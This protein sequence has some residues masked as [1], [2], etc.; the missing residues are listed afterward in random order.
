MIDLFEARLAVTLANSVRNA[1]M[2]KHEPDAAL[3]QVVLGEALLRDVAD[4]DQPTLAAFW[5]LHARYI[6]LPHVGTRL[7]V[8][9]PVG[10]DVQCEQSM[11]LTDNLCE[12]L[13]SYGKTEA[14]QPISN[15]A[16]AALV[17]DGSAAGFFDD[18]VLFCLRKEGSAGFCAQLP[19]LILPGSTVTLL[20]PH[21]ESEFMWTAMLHVDLNFSAVAEA[22]ATKYAVSKIVDEVRDKVSVVVYGIEAKE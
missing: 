8:N 19:E 5:A 16:R 1:R 7:L 6:R 4:P 15:V 17:A 10:F 14:V 11:T 2:G 22:V 21:V 12:M 18:V 3:A 13:G 9:P 20:R